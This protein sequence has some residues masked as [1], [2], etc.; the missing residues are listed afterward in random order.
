M[1]LHLTGF[2]SSGRSRR[3]PLHIPTAF[4]SLHRREAL[5]LENTSSFS[6]EALNVQSLRLL[7]LFRKHHFQE[8]NSFR[9]IGT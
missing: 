6:M 1:G 3:N 5:E 2:R 7:K 9:R 8:S 4:C